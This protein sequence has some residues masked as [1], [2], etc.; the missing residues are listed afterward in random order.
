MNANAGAPGGSS[1]TVDVVGILD[2]APFRGLSVRVSVLTVLA[3]VFDGFD[4]QAIAFAAPAL[5]MEFGITRPQLGPILAAGLIGMALGAFALGALGD[6]LGRRAALVASLALIAVTS[7]G[8]VFA[9]SPDEMLAWR[10]LTG[11]GLG[12]VTPN[13]TALMVEFAPLSVRNVVVALTVVGVP[14]GGVLGAE[15][16]AQLMPLFGWRSI[17]LVGAVLPGTLA[18]VLLLS[19]PESPRYLARLGGQGAELAGL[20]NRVTRSQS[21]DPSMAFVVLESQ[22][23]VAR[24]R[25]AAVLGTEFRRDTLLIWMIFATNIFAVYAFFNWLPTVLA[26]VGLPMS[27]A[28]RGSLIFN[29]GGVV[30]SVLVAMSVS[31]FGSRHTLRVVGI[32]AIVTTM[33]MGFVAPTDVTALLMLMA[34][35]GGCILGMQV[36]MYAVAANVYPTAVRSTGVGWASAIARLGG[37]A[38]SLIGGVLLSLGQGMT[39]FLVAVAL[40]LVPTLIGVWLLQRHMPATAARGSR[41]G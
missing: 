36:C 2:R 31:R 9:S 18:L 24:S 6:R 10:F 4:I 17:F 21:F 28:L 25:V 8:T 13:C 12:G 35:A 38:S 40:V 37:I 29:L 3:M 11:I 14:L 27:I 20:L 39:P 41:R 1:A 23:S 22:T 26:S 34:L 30:A 16:A 33:A 32:G 15:V 7:L 19:L 5:L